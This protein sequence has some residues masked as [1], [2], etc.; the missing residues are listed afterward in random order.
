MLEI[1]LAFI[2]LDVSPFI[3]VSYA[4]TLL[5]LGLSLR[6]KGLFLTLPTKFS[7]LGSYR[8]SL[9]VLIVHDRQ[10]IV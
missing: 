5:V 6:T 7:A 8:S 1:L 2:L 9:C 4:C 3:S 10:E